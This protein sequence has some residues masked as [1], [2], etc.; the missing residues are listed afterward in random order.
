M[1]N[2][3][4]TL[5]TLVELANLKDDTEAIDRFLSAHPFY[6][7]T[8]EME[9]AHGNS[10]DQEVL[11]VRDEVQE[12][13]RGGERAD[14]IAQH[15]LITEAISAIS[16]RLPSPAGKKAVA[17]VLVDWKRG[18]LRLAFSAGNDFRTSIYELLKLSRFAR[19]CARPDCAAA[20]FVAKDLRT[21]YCSTDCSD[22][23]QE[24]WRLDWWRKNGDTWREQRKAGSKSKS[25]GG[26]R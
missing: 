25:K 8:L 6:I 14:Q 24:Q 12:L 5:A 10:I 11:R 16:E 26:K 1:D 23:M 2:Y 9:A 17:P 13:W 15:Y 19:I 3:T 18:E 21:R 20:F 22:L 4:D 7:E